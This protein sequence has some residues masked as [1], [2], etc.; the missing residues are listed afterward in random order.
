MP[1]MRALV[2]FAVVVAAGCGGND[3]KPADIT[4]QVYG[5][6]S[7]TAAGRPNFTFTVKKVDPVSTKQA[8]FDDA[9]AGAQLVCYVHL[10]E[11]YLDDAAGEPF[12]NFLYTFDA[13]QT[14]ITSLDQFPNE[15][16]QGVPSYHCLEQ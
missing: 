1:I 9:N 13:S 11:L 4:D 16:G 14:K 15:D 5:T 3:E 12:R 8:W 7:C 2:A 10:T 6:W